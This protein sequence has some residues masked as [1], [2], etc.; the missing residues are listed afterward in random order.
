MIFALRLS[1]PYTGRR[2]SLQKPKGYSSLSTPKNIEF[3][4]IIAHSGRL[5]TNFFRFLPRFCKLFSTDGDFFEKLPLF[6]GTVFVLV[7]YFML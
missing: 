4:T 6:S 1:P 7:V 2:L 5:S 3:L